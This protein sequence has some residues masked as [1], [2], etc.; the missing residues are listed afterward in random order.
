[1]EL[2]K[3]CSPIFVSFKLKLKCNPPPQK[4]SKW[5]TK[6]RV[7][8]ME[9][10]QNVSCLIG[11]LTKWKVDKMESWQNGKL[12]KWKVDKME[13]WQ[14]GESMKWNVDKMAS[15]QNVSSLIGKLAACQLSNW[16]V[17]KNCEFR[18]LQVHKIVSRQNSNL[19]KWWV[20]KMESW[21]NGKLTKWWVYKTEKCTPYTP[22][23]KNQNGGPNG[24]LMKW[25]VDK[26]E[27][28]QNGKLAKCQ[29]SNCQVG[30]MSVV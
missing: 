12:T 8:E 20:N 1:M 4:K 16:Q 29:L 17:D 27:W 28:W 6:W 9:C 3:M 18:K 7:D 24:E 11:K 22:P 23:V 2:L 25:W 21:Q 14:N 5:L 15:W 19:T 13:S 10:W 30:N 26:M